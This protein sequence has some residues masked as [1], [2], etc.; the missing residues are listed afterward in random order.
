MVNSASAL[1]RNGIHDWLLLRGA[2]IVIALYVF[3]IIGFLIISGPLTYQSWHGFFSHTFTR[4]FTLLTLLSILVH[5]WIGLWQVLTDYIKQVAVRL[6]LQGLIVVA[7]LTYVLY[8]TI[9][10]WGV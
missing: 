6:V 2:A 9:I 8:G 3:F 7:L 10:V 1:G 4:V 5:A